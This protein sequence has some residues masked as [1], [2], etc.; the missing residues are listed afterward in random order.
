[1]TYAAWA[2]SRD[3]AIAVKAMRAKTTNPMINRPNV[4]RSSHSTLTMQDLSRMDMTHTLRI[5]AYRT[6]GAALA[7]V[8]SSIASG[9]SYET[10]T[11]YQASQ[12]VPA[13]LL[14]GPYHKV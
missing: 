11:D 10:L 2:V 3:I 4:L 1:M 14:S 12:L 8:V 6:L 13:A 9:Q 5:N 7:V